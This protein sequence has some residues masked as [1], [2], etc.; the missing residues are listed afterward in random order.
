MVEA[1]QQQTDPKPNEE[2]NTEGLTAAELQ[3]KEE[4]EKKKDE[5][6][7]KM[8]NESQTGPDQGV[9]DRQIRIQRWD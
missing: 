9:F 1:T 4:E 8:W 5:E 6:R 7:I 3:L 2:N